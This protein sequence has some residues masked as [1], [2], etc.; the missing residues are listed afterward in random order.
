M[1]A[2]PELHEE[3]RLALD[4]GDHD[5]VLARLEPQ[6]DGW[7]EEVLACV[8]LTESAGDALAVAGDLHR[9]VRF[10]RLALTGWEVEASMAT[11]GGEGMQRMRDVER[12]R[13]KLARAS[14]PAP[15]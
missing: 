12:V 9:A 7:A 2:L 15:P 13:E 5:G 11:S 14:G 1:R 6:H 3:I 4:A 10:W 8:G